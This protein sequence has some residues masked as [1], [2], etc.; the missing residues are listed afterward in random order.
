MTETLTLYSSEVCPFAQRTVIALQEAK[1]D[2]TKYEI[3]LS[4]KPEWY[5]PKINPAS[6]VPAIAYGG[7][8]VD[9]ANPSPESVK[10]AESL[11]LLEFIADLYPNSGLL[12]TNPVERAQA[13]FIIDVFSTKVLPANLALVWKGESPE[14]LY[15]ALLAFQD[16]L[17]LHAKPFLG[18]D[19]INIADAAVAPFLIRLE[20]HLKKDVGG[21][22]VRGDGSNIYNEL[23]KSER[24]ENFSKYVHALLGRETIKKSF[25]E[26]S[27]VSFS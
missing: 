10:L 5:A 2:Y 20:A 4:N 1:A 23:F 7:P 14:P 12:S 8:K 9:P 25:P 3:D 18:G 17:K 24:F 21:F 19:K 22:V 6:K 27:K 26:V 13:R 15:D 16:Q 11:V